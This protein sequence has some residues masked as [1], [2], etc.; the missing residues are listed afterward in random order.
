MTLLLIIIFVSV[1]FLSTKKKSNQFFFKKTKSGSNRPVSIRLF[2]NKNR[3]FSGLARF[4]QFGSDFS[5]W[6]CFFKFDSFFQ[7]FSVWVQFGFFGFRLIKPKP[8]RTGRFFK[9]HNRFNRF[10]RFFFMVQ[11]FQLFFPVF[12]VF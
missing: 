2:Q 11:F 7:F 8:N 6:L 10:N 5:V 3:L 9:N 12:S 1:Q 4:F